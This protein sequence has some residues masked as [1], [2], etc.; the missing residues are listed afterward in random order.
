[1]FLA[2][3]IGLGFGANQGVITVIAFII[4]STIVIITKKFSN[5]TDENQN[6]HLTISSQNPNKIGADNI[7]QTLK[8]H[9]SAVS[10]Q[11]LDETGEFIEVSLFVEFRDFEQLN[12]TKRALQQIDDTLKFSFLDNKSVY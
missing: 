10:L 5:E 9:C 12:E 4:I 8:K 7:I 3:G 2:I 11:R 6:L 1:M